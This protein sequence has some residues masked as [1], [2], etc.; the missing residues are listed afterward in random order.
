MR[1]PAGGGRCWEE[2][3]RGAV[4]VIFGSLILV[5]DVFT[6]EVLRALRVARSAIQMLALAIS[7]H[8]RGMAQRENGF[9]GSLIVP[10][11]DWIRGRDEEI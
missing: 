11:H 10:D 1:H 9:V 6:Q 2:V 5:L 4:T 3:G 7:Q 8:E